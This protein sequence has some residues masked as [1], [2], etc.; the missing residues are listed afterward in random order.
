MIRWAPISAPTTAQDFFFQDLQ[1]KGETESEAFRKARNLVKFSKASV[2]V[3]LREI[4]RC[5]RS[6]RLLVLFVYRGTE[7]AQ[8][9]FP[10]IC[11][12]NRTLDP[13]VV[14]AQHSICLFLS[15][16]R[17]R[18]HKPCMF[19]G[20]IQRNGNGS[21]FSVAFLGDATRRFFS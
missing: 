21:A 9:G 4:I 1:L 19:P 14:S 15:V 7:K 8:I 12:H 18:K 13:R 2:T 11:I 20:R 3:L 6:D 10:Q 5:T 16:F 17:P